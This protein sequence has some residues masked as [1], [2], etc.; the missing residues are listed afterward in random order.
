MRDDLCGSAALYS[1]LG[2]IG[3]DQYVAASAVEGDAD[4]VQQ[5][6]VDNPLCVAFIQA[7]QLLAANPRRPSCF[8]SRISHRSCLSISLGVPCADARSH[9]AFLHLSQSCVAGPFL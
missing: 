3:N 6:L 8:L 2:G 9:R 1:A 4:I 7:F 5:V